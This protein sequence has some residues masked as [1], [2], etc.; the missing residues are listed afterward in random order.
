MTGIRAERLKNKCIGTSLQ[1]IEEYLARGDLH[2]QSPVDAAATIH[3]PEQ[4]QHQNF[5][6]TECCIGLCICFDA[7]PLFIS[8]STP[9]VVVYSM[10]LYY[11]PCNSDSSSLN[12]KA[13]TLP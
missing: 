13:I 12:T 9:T 3:R 2:K 11:F 5:R 4:Q 7:C 1:G 8:L 10:F 6:P